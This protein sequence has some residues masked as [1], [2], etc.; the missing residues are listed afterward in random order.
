MTQFFNLPTQKNLKIAFNLTRVD[1]PSVVFLTGLK[2]DMSGT[3]AMAIEEYCNKNDLTMLRFD[4]LGHGQSS[5]PFQKTT[6]F[7]WFDCTVELIKGLNLGPSII[8]GSSLGGWLGLI[9]SNRHPE[10]VEGFVGIASAPEFTDSILNDLSKVEKEKLEKEGAISIPSDYDEPY[11]FTRDLLDSGS[12][13]RVFDKRFTIQCPVRL[14]HG[15]DDKDVDPNVS[16]RLLNHID[17]NDI[18]LKLL[19]DADHRFSDERCLK[20]VTLAINSIRESLVISDHPT[21]TKIIGK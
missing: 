8:V 20:W 7:D 18:S 6:L 10:L 1:S 9:L 5:L 19:Q 17:C 2:S 4:Y 14:L 3:K 15:L 11:V 21:E 12:K 16:K 13:F